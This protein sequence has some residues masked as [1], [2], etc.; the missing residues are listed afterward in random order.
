MANSVLLARLAGWRHI[1]TDPAELEQ[2]DAQDKAILRNL[3]RQLQ[4]L[5]EGPSKPADDE[6][7]APK[8]EDVPE[9]HALPQLS[10]N[11]VLHIEGLIR[12][13]ATTERR[14]RE[15]APFFTDA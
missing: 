8:A 13:A 5:R 3:L 12:A 1:F 6:S 10:D 15:Q 7:A 11:E 2:Q 14:N 4:Q 9:A